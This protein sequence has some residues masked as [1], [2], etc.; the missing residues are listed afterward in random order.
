MP[1]A[2][3]RWSRAAEFYAA[4]LF[5]SYAVL[6]FAHAG[7]PSLTDYANWTY[8]GILLREHLIGHADPAHILK[9]YPVPNSLTTLGIGVLA[10]VLP[11]LIATKLWLAVQLGFCYAAMRLLLRTVAAPAVAWVV[12]PQAVFLN[13]NFWYGFMNFELGLAWV[14]LFAALLLRAARPWMLGVV[15]VLVFFTHMIPFCFCVLLLLLRVAESKRWRELWAALPAVVLTV[16][17]VLGRFLLAANADGQAGMQE[18]VPNYSAAFW[19]FKVN[20]YAK[21]FGFANPMG[22]DQAILGRAGFYVLLLAEALLSALVAWGLLRAYRASL[23]SGR[24]RFLWRALLLVVPVYLLSPGTAL[25]ISDPG[26]RIL[27]T[28]LALALV[29]CW[30]SMSHGPRAAAEACGGVL[31]AGGLILFLICGASVGSTPRPQPGTHAKAAAF[32]RVPNTDQDYF[33]TALDHGD[34][35]LAVFPTGMLLNHGALPAPASER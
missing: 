14:M 5:L 9:A 23:T 8:Q 29:L 6:V 21:S 25:G 35:R 20:S 24:E 1:Q 13:V 7:A 32:A 11:W 16:W 28:A 4:G 2:K 22:V 10:L 18:T 31:A 30:R 33:Y 26:A 15:L 34:L 19:L 27:Q 17:Y 12:V 3:T